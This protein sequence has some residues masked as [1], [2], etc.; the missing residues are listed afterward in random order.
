MRNLKRVLS[1]ALAS[2]MLLGMMVIGAGAADKTAADLTDMDKVTNKEA[3]SLMVDLGI[4]VGK[5]DGSYAPTEGVDRAT[6]AKLITYVLMGDVDAAIFEGTKTDL[7][8]IDTNWA[9]GYIKYCYSNGII[10]GDG[11]GHFF[12][13]QGVTVVQAA[14]MLLVALGYE[15][16][17]RGYQNDS[18]WSVNIMKDAQTSGLMTGIN[19]KA[20][21]TLTRDGAAQMIFNALFANTVEPKYAYDMGVQYVTEYTKGNTLGYITYNLVKLTATVDGIVNGKADISATTPTGYQNLVDE[22]L[23]ATPDMVGTQV[24]VYGKGTIDNTGAVTAVTKLYSTS[25][26]AG[27]TNVLG[28]ST[29]GTSIADLSNPNKKAFI[30]E[31][32]TGVKYILNGVTVG[33][34]S[35]GDVVKGSVVEFI[36]T[37]DDNKAEIVKVTKKTPAKLTADP[38]ITTKNGKTTVTIAEIG[39]ANKDAANVVGYEGLAKGDA[40]LY[41]TVGG[42]TYIEKAEKITGAVSGNNSTKGALID[43]TYYL[44]SG[45]GG[46]YTNSSINDTATY[47]FYLDNGGYILYADKVTE[48]TAATSLAVVDQVAWVS[49]P[50]DGS[51]GSKNTAYMQAKL[52][53]TDGTTKIVT[54]ASVDGVVPV[55]QN[56]AIADVTS[57]THYNENTG[58]NLAA[59]VAKTA[60]TSGTAVSTDTFDIATAYYLVGNGA[61]G[62]VTARYYAVSG[63]ADLTN[64]TAK[65][66]TEN[67][68]YNYSVNSKGEYVLT[69]LK[70]EQGANTAINAAITGIKPNFTGSLNGNA[71]TVFIYATQN[72]DG[73]YTYTVYNGIANAPTT[74]SAVNGYAIVKGAVATYVYVDLGKGSTVTES[75]DLVYILSNDYTAVTGETAYIYDVLLNGETTTL[76]LAA[77]TYNAGE[78]YEVGSISDKDV[79]TLKSD[80]LAKS[81]KVGIKS[82]DGNVL[83]TGSSVYSYESGTPAYVVDGKNATTTTV[84]ALALD[85]NDKVV[86]FETAVNS[87]IVSVVYVT[88][89]SQEPATV[90]LAA[91]DNV[92]VSGDLKAGTAA[93]TGYVADS[94]DEVKISVATPTTGTT[95]DSISINGTKV[96]V[97]DDYTL[98]GTGTYNVVV[99][100]KDA[101]SGALSSFSY[102]FTV[103]A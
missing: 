20:T 25:L 40:V 55:A 83:I 14:K 6:M 12:P 99:T 48:G 102:S 81:P 9:E 19:A 22:K 103:A 74:A 37:D 26:S 97:G 38:T 101:N 43:G 78:L 27:T 93:V 53:F 77:N 29:N 35:S 67:Q 52:V 66:I 76:K 11:L 71:N 69:S 31:L 86:V 39:I 7:T 56:T 5:P 64:T 65:F 54:V 58:S 23:P 75:S 3:V 85:G 1:L 50:G 91:V 15:A 41:T 92:S 2:V 84:D 24:V 32:D 70:A 79:Y 46:T 82:V 30:A 47:D 95:V 42:V 89:V 13:T 17:D 34:I 88:K 36:S 21:D 98:T 28:T 4:I 87:K 73:E 49:T 68:F 80:N 90:T 59:E 33:S 18:S 100:V 60:L 72:S 62:A 8:D 45:L 10:T 63:V 61:T 44:A 51:I 94:A 96:S 57:A 16:E